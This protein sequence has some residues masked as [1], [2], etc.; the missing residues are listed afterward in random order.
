MSDFE[1]QMHKEDYLQHTYHNIE[2][3]KQKIAKLKEENRM[4]VINVR[5]NE[6]TMIDLKAQID[7]LQLY[8]NDAKEE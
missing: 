8:L 7:K 6:S 1:N 3:M 4:S 5:M 2:T